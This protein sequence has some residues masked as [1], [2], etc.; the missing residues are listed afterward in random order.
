VANGLRQSGAGGGL[1]AGG[2]VFVQQGGTLIIS[3]GTMAN[4]EATGGEGSGPGQS[5]QGYG[6]G[7]FI[8]GSQSITFGTGQTAGRVTTINGDITDQSGSD[9]TNVYNDPGHGSVIIAGNGTVVLGGDNTYTG[10]TKIESGT[11]DLTS[12]HAAGSGAITFDPGTLEFTV[13]DAPTNEIDGFG[14]GDTIQIDGFVEQSG[15]Y[16]NNKLTLFG[17]NGSGGSETVTLD[18]PGLLGSNFSIHLTSTTTTIGYGTGEND[19]ACYCRGTLIATADGEVPVETLEIGDD[20]VTACGASRPIKWIGKRSYAGHFIMGRSD[21]LPVCIKAG[22]LG[23]N[24]PKRDLWISPHH[25]MH[26][27]EQGGVLVEAKDLV[28]GVSIVQIEAVDKVEYFHIE[29]ESHDV[30]VAE[31]ALSETFLDDDSRAMFHNAH[32]Y[33]TLYAEAPAAAVQYCAPRCDS[34]YEL[35]AVRRAIALRAGL[36]GDDRA[37]ALRGHVDAI[38]PSLVKGWAQ[39]IDHPEAPVCLDIYADGRLIG[40]V[41]ANRYRDD[42]AKAGL[43]SGR[44][45]FAFRPPAGVTLT[46]ETIEVR[47][48]LDGAPLEGSEDFKQTKQRVA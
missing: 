7:I 41:L 10:G 35:E 17:T 30:I 34:G 43:G 3:G 15:V 12:A 26:F 48:S 19:I 6:D 39:T 21:I 24:V 1:G 11:L 46:P 25:A 29:L 37:G 31:G 5:G 22:A 18:M 33:E 20:V 27:G 13:A 47:R 14:A 23:D 2:D 44:H 8:Q 38:T 36:G 45:G 42:L 4:G 40:Q 16:Q 28:N 9:P 32:E